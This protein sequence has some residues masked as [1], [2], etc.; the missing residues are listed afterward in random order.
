MKKVY[1]RQAETLVCN[2]INHITKIVFLPC[3]K[4]AFDAAIT[5]NNILGG[6]QGASLT[7]HDPGAVILKLDVRLHIRYRRNTQ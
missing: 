2:Q 4:A 1:G 6:V 5:K 3:F 7:L